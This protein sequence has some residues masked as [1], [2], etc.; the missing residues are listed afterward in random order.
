MG[1]EKENESRGNRQQMNL[2]LCS[3]A[4]GDRSEKT[5]QTTAEVQLWAHTSCGL[6][7]PKQHLSA[8][9]IFPASAEGQPALTSVITSWDEWHQSAASETESGSAAA[10]GATRPRRASYLIETKRRRAGATHDN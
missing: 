9:L 6:T 1:I 3:E 2:H 7:S 10:A 5:S 4:S 8:F